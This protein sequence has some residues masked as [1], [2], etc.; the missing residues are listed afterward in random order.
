MPYREIKVGD[1]VVAR[2]WRIC[3]Q[4]ELDQPALVLSV[5]QERLG[6]WLECRAETKYGTQR[7]YCWDFE[8]KHI[9]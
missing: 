2:T 6:D 8:V 9:E 7:F 1:Q 3:P 4:L 5:A